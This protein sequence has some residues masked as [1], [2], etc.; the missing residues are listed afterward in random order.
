MSSNTAD[1]DLFQDSFNKLEP[2]GFGRANVNLDPENLS[3]EAKLAH[4]FRDR[5][6][7]LA[8][9][10]LIVV[11]FVWLI[12]MCNAPNDDAKEAALYLWMAKC[13]LTTTV[14][15]S[16]VLG[17]LNFAIKCYGHHNNREG[18]TASTGDV[19]SIQVIGKIADAFGKAASN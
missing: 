4:E 5:A 14:F 8:A 18:I 2:E 12:I 17:L 7:S 19:T 13:A 11:G 3:E 9:C 15:L 10:A 6:F 1:E 16:F